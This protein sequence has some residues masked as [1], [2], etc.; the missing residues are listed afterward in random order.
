MNIMSH[1]EAM[2]MSEPHD[3]GCCLLHAGAHTL[4]LYANC[5]L[6][7]RQNRAKA[8]MSHVACPRSKGCEAVDVNL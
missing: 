7:T 3:C 5:T 4:S 6:M 8:G 2:T 1:L